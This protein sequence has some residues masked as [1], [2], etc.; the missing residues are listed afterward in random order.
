MSRRHKH[1]LTPDDLDAALEQSTES[2]ASQHLESCQACQDLLEAERELVGLLNG[3]PRF[4][5]S[6]E[7]VDA[8]MARVAIPDPFALRAF[9]NIRSRLA[10]SHRSLAFAT[11]IA[12]VLAVTMG[13]SIAWTMA[14]QDVLAAIGSS[15]AGEAAHW[16]WLGLQALASNLVEQPWYE[17]A[18]AAIGSP[19]RL[20]LFSGTASL[21]YLSGVLALKRL[22]ALPAQR[23]A[24]VQI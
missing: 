10:T 9:R 24:H 17:D 20:A 22:L 5:P 14:N 16:F 18:R 23:V 15:V 21:L 7:F 6:P 8:V 11:S 13:G 4:S 1:H 12:V 3:M 19:T 2:Q